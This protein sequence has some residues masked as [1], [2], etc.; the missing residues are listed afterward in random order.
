VEGELWENTV[1]DG[2]EGAGFDFEGVAAA[3]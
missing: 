1:K 2:V 3:A